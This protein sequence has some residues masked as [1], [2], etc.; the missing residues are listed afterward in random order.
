MTWQERRPPRT[1]LIATAAM[2]LGLVLPGCQCGG[3][4][5]VDGGG[6]PGE[7]VLTAGDLDDSWVVALDGGDEAWGIALA[8]AAGEGSTTWQVRLTGDVITGLLELV[9]DDDGINGTLTQTSFDGTMT[10]ASIATSALS[11]DHLRGS[12]TVDGVPVDIDLYRAEPADGGHSGVWTRALDQSPTIVAAHRGTLFISALDAAGDWAP[13]GRFDG[14]VPDTDPGFYAAAFPF[15]GDAGGSGEGAFFDGGGRLVLID[16]TTGGANA[17]ELFTRTET[18][19]PLSGLWVTLDRS[20]VDVLAHREPAVVVEHD[21]T[22]FVHHMNGLG[23]LQ[24]MVHQGEGA[25]VDT[26]SDAPWRGALSADGLRMIGEWEGY[27]GW[28]A[29]MVRTSVPT[30]EAIA[31]TFGSLTINRAFSTQ[32][33]PYGGEAA[34]SFDGTTLNVTDVD[35][36]GETSMLSATWQGDHFAGRWWPEGQPDGGGPWHGYWLADGQLLSG[37]WEEGE[38]SFSPFPVKRDSDTFENVVLVAAPESER[39]LSVVDDVDGNILSLRRD[40]ERITSAR[41]S[42]DQGDFQIEVDERMRP[43]RIVSEA[44]DIALTWG[45]GGEVEIVVDDLFGGTQTTVNGVVDLSDEA[46]LAGFDAQ[47]LATGRDLSAARQWVTDHPG[48]VALRAFGSAGLSSAEAPITQ[49]DTGV[50]TRVNGAAFQLG[51]MLVSLAGL[52]ATVPAAAVATAVVAGAAIV[53]GVIV[54]A[55]LVSDLLWALLFDA[56]CY[57]CG[58]GCF[59]ACCD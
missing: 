8:P 44:V 12:A 17:A 18:A 46:L 33:P 5:P 50:Y 52:L 7:I 47:E 19:G 57:P 38:W 9:V 58:L 31:G 40:Q 59:F 27:E 45:A 43:T 56:C 13:E 41:V 25:F 37:V 4:A 26:T 23:R 34:M 3:T 24:R 14:Q 53:C 55:A 15:F 28:W 10:S 42:T 49:L 51:A 6:G 20:T 22:L 29:S 11:L 2:A 16:Q 54:I 36:Y 48:L 1:R 32:E 30:S 35:E 21:D 39:L